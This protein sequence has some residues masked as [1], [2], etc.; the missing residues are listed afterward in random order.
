M[1]PPPPPL[2]SLL[3]TRQVPSVSADLHDPAWLRGLSR[4]KSKTLRSLPGVTRDAWRRVLETRLEWIRPL[5]EDCDDDSGVY[6]LIRQGRV[7]Y[8]G[9]SRQVSIRLQQHFAHG[10]EWDEVHLL[11]VDSDDEHWGRTG[12]DHLLD[13][14]ESVLIAT[15]DPPLNFKRCHHAW[16]DHEMWERKVGVHQMRGW[17][18]LLRWLLG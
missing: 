10:K 8:V 1:T 11:T 3:D 16:W 7:V 9:R 5:T 12:W 13:Q 18:A 15:I 14:I 17:I 6:L 2:S 4:R